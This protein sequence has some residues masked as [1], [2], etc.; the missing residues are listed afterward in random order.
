MVKYHSWTKRADRIVLYWVWNGLMSPRTVASLG[1]KV[2]AWRLSDCSPFTAGCTFPGSCIQFETAC[3]R[4][5]TLPEKIRERA[6]SDFERR[7]QN[8]EKTSFAVIAPSHWIASMAQRSQLFR[9]RRVEVIHSGIDT[10]VFA[11]MERSEARRLLD[12]LS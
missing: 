8:Y 9:A 10:G 4:C 5:P 3:E 12:V 2:V 7:K 6:I 11:P 1:R